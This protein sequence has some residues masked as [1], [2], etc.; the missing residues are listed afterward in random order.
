MLPKQGTF[1]VSE[2]NIGSYKLIEIGPLIV[3][4][5]Y[6]YKIITTNEEGG[7][8]FHDMIGD[9]VGMGPISGPES[10]DFLHYATYEDA[11]GDR[12]FG[13]AKG[14]FIG[15]ASGKGTF[16]ILGGTGKYEGI[17]GNG[18]HSF[19]G[20]NYNY[21]DPDNPNPDGPVQAKAKKK[22]QYTMP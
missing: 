11:D 2:V 18:E 8:L 9:G 14:E 13:C 12:I 5:I 17:Q 7:G 15:P 3:A 10:D 20:L 1:S 19:E 4:S 6:F 21:H 22:G 16:A